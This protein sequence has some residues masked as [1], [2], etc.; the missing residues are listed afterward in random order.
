[1]LTT[2]IRVWPSSFDTRCST[3][4]K[5]GEK[6]LSIF[7]DVNVKYLKLRGDVLNGAGQ[8]E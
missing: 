2:L 8:P 4:F 1:M 3:V 5:P 6:F 7:L